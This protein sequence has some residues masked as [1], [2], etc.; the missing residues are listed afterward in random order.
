MHQIQLYINNNCKLDCIG[1]PVL[2]IFTGACYHGTAIKT[3]TNK[4]TI[5]LFYLQFQLHNHL[6]KVANFVSHKMKVYIKQVTNFEVHI[7]DGKSFGEKQDFAE[8][9]I[10]TDARIC[11]CFCPCN[12]SRLHQYTVLLLKTLGLL[13]NYFRLIFHVLKM[14]FRTEASRIYPFVSYIAKDCSIK[15][16]YLICMISL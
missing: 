5:Q 3:L 12:V 15:N 6:L 7:E 16:M 13:L 1:Q 9:E 11:S 8:T 14:R 2:F 10:I 4:Y